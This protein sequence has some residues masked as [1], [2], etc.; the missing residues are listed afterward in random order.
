MKGRGVEYQI[1]DMVSV[2]LRNLYDSARGQPTVGERW[3]R[4][5]E[6]MLVAGGLTEEQEV[7][8]RNQ[9]IEARL[10]DQ[11]GRV[12]AGIFVNAKLS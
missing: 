12:Q 4:A 11:Q 8:F 9:I 5:I 6:R 7:E 1:G 2:G 10:L 3:I